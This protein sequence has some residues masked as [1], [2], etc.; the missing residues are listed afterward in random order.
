ML[1]DLRFA[2]HLIVKDRWYSAVAIVALSLGI[3]LNATVFTL[4]NA[5]ILRG[6]PYKDAQQL[7][8]I[9]ALRKDNPRPGDISLPELRDWQAQSK[10]FAGLAGTSD[11][12]VTLSGDGIAPQAAQDADLTANTFSL[13]SQPLLFGRDFLPSDEQPGAERVAIIGYKL[14]KT[15]YTEDRHVLGKV[16]KIDGTA[17]TIVGVM[18]EGMEFP[19]NTELWTPV[20]PTADRE[21]R[22]DRFLSVFG[23]LKPGVSLKEATVEFNGVAARLANAYPDTNQD[24]P[25]VIIQTFNER[26]NGPQITIVFLALLGAVG[27]VLVIACAN[28][29]NLLLSRSV[30]RSR[31]IA[32]RIALGA[33]RWRVV[34]Q[35]LIESVCL[36]VISGVVALGIAIVGVR[37]FDA[38]VANTGKPYWIRFTM[39][40]AV[41]A[42][43]AGICVLTGVLF[44][45]APALQVTKTNV[46]DVLKE[47]GRGNAGTVRARWLT[48][49]MVVIELAL[50]LVLLVGAGLMMRSFLKLYTLDIGIQTTN[51]MNMRMTLPDAKY[52]TP[53]ARRAFYDRLQEKLSSVAGL[54]SS[55]LTTAVPP[56]GST[57]R[58]IEIE[59]APPRGPEDK[60]PRVASVSITP[61]F[62]QTMGVQVLR[63]RP[64][65]ATDGDQG[66][67][68]VIINDKLAAEFFKG[69]DPIGRRLR[70]AQGQ[71]RPGTPPPPVPVWRTIVG[72][73]PTI[74]HSPPQQGFSQAAVY[75]PIRTEAPGFVNL[76][77]RSRLAPGSVVSAVRAEVQAL[78]PDQPVSEI[79]TFADMMQQ[80]MWA[81]RVFGGLFAIFAGIALVMSAVGLYAV[82]AYSVTQRTAELGVRMALGAGR[83]SVIWLIFRRGLWQMG[84]GLGLG[85]AA[86][87][88][89]SRVLQTLLVDITATDP[90]TFGTITVLLAAVATAACLI[91]AR[92]ATRVDPLVAL[93]AD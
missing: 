43:L 29:A 92:R 38:A 20:V 35:L 16:V 30:H 15:R 5:V 23:R 4:V 1:R 42:Y 17:T 84:I 41:F 86:A 21:K 14:W 26:V 69:E 78:D 50:T 45:L 31:E 67:D 82:M 74:R 10:S 6:L 27:F 24:Y 33:T 48:G 18:P 47:G 60:A 58:G 19:S 76:M 39:D 71:A 88:A 32:V 80:Q 13:L 3:G 73:S 65:T 61:G 64:F 68:N 40:Y 62:F 36:G 8:V 52:K 57:R 93:R 37:L 59:G 12:D 75:V 63:G 44:G 81:Y 7:Y 9:G 85:L 34:R 83:G 79:R 11:H 55:A 28:V 2:L 87:V 49:T 22:G 46:N 89:V 51:L 66:F 70:F 77:V 72:I 54:E 56:F 53:E 91:P 90:V 25:G